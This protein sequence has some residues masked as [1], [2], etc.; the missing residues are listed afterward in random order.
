MGMKQSQQEKGPISRLLLV[1]VECK[2]DE[3]KPRKKGANKSVVSC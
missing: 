3:T 1:E 2:G